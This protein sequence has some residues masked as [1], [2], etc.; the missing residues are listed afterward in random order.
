MPDL[1]SN[2]PKEVEDLFDHLFCVWRNAGAAF[3]VQKHDVHVAVRIKLSAAVAAERHHGQWS[4]GGALVP[5]GEGRG[6]RKDMAEDDVD[7]PD[8]ESANLAPASSRLVA[9]AQPGVLD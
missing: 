7:Q 3:V 4:R 5:A 8:A 2:I 9:Q 1:E 6:R